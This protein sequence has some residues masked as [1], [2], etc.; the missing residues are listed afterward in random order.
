MLGQL[1]RMSAIFSGEIVLEVVLMANLILSGNGLLAK[2]ASVVS[3]SGNHG[4][5]VVFEILNAKQ[6]SAIRSFAPAARS[7]GTAAVADSIRFADHLFKVF[8]ADAVF[9]QVV[10]DFV[11]PNKLVIR[12]CRGSL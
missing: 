3:G 2:P 11:S 6:E 4:D 5:P 12:H 7:A 10:D 1:A 9:R 8:G